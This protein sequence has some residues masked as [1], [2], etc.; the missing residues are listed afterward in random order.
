MNLIALKSPS[1]RLYFTGSFFSVYGLWI[2]R[3][4]VGWLAWDMTQSA[5]FV[6]LVAALSLIPSFVGGP[7]FGVIIDRTNIKKA[8]YFTNGAMICCVLLLLGIH[9]TNQ[10]TPLLLAVIST[11]IGMVSSAHHPVRMSLAPRLVP[12]ENVS[13]V[14]ALA[15]LNFNSAR[16]IS[17]A[18]GGLIIDQ[19]G[20]TAA[21]IVSVFFYLPAILL[22]RFMHPR[23]REAKGSKEPFLTAL[24]NGFRYIAN[25][26]ELR[27]VIIF[28]AFMALSVR[29]IAEILPVV[30]D[31][32]FQKGPTGLGQ[33]GSAV[34]C[35]ALIAAVAKSLGSSKY[36][37]MISIQTLSMTVLGFISIVI[38]GTSSEWPLTLI[39]A[40]VLGFCS[41]HLGVTLQSSMQAGLPDDMRGRVMSLWIVIA[42]GASA[43]GAYMIGIATDIFGLPM[44]SLS[45][46]LLCTAFLSWIVFNAAKKEGG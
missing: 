21:L 26:P 2:M 28:T 29:G 34:G 3:V 19:L 24:T 36:H 39:A 13:S 22:I 16:M 4:L 6:G 43:L 1:F 12:K 17:P 37:K 46:S 32:V 23:E 27:L 38:F 41:T 33:L 5:S 31:G 15:A 30:A 20:I 18:L 40:A 11:L 14:I 9:L 7:F 8:A 25:R 45:L 10:L 42:T 44:A 35:G